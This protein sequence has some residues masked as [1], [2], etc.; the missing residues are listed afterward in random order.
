LQQIDK[1]GI[2]KNENISVVDHT[3]NMAW[4]KIKIDREQL[5][6]VRKNQTIKDVSSSLKTWTDRERSLE[7]SEDAL[8]Q[9]KFEE[10]KINDKISWAHLIVYVK[11]PDQPD[12]IKVPAFRDAFV[13][14]ANMLLN[15]L[16][17]LIWLAPFII[18]FLIIWLKRHA[19]KR[20]LTRKK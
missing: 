6:T 9:A 7:Q 12:R 19:I 8:D 18:V 10:W 17:A 20:L 1:L 16:Y 14:V 2:L 5:R 3:E 11:G 13:G 15:I 4:Q